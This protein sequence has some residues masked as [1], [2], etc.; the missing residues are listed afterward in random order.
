M[1]THRTGRGRWSLLR[2]GA[3]AFAVALAGCDVERLLEIDDPEFT[4]PG[5]APVASTT[6]GAV[7]EMQRAY[8]GAAAN[9]HDEGY[10]SVS[11]AMADEFLLAGT[12]PTRLNT[13]RR[14]LRPP[15]DGNHSDGTYRWLHR[16]RRAA[17]DA[18]V[19]L[20]EDGV[21][22]GSVVAR[23]HAFEAFPYV[24]LGEGWCGAVPVSDFVDG[25]FVHGPMLTTVELFEHAIQRFDRA[26]SAADNYRLAAVGKGRALVN[27]GRFEEAAAAVADVPTSFIYFF[28]HDNNSSIQRNNIFALQENGRW[29][30]A[31]SAGGNGLPY[32]ASGDPRVPWIQLGGRAAR[33]FDNATAQFHSQRYRQTDNSPDNNASNFVLADGIEARLIEAEAALHAGG[34]WL[35]ILNDLRANFRT[36]MA[37]RYGVG[38]Y[39]VNLEAGVAA[40]RLQPN[41]P[42]LEDPGDQDARIDLLFEERAYWLYLTGHRLGD[43]RRL[44][45]APYN[46]PV[47]TIFPV[48]AYHKGGTYGTDVNFSIPFDEQNNIN[49]DPAACVTTQP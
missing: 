9:L 14:T 47:E 12:F 45:R 22:T 4:G 2:L 19:A 1:T 49:Y 6:A 46:R 17:I 30:M 32:L 33:G 15:A 23:S 24:A 25:Q 29:T 28:E 3:V 43:M 34:D 42:P 26:A 35:G 27:L 5:E 31:N 39:P 11:A 37:A 21:T 38:N 20:A 44:A 16:A 7:I 8:S 10:A 41:L 48:G 40:G 36:L 18:L 13:N